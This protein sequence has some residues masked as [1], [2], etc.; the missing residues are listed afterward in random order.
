MFISRLPFPHRWLIYPS[1]YGTDIRLIGGIAAT[2]NAIGGISTEIPQRECGKERIYV[3]TKNDEASRRGGKRQTRKQDV[4]VI[5][6]S[7]YVGDTPMAEA[8]GSAVIDSYKRGADEENA[9]A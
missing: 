4:K 2:P 3:D 5:V 8:I 9:P 1:I 6:I 7:L